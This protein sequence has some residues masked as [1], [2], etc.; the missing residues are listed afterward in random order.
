[1][2]IDSIL[3]ALLLTLMLELVFALL[4]GLRR[5]Q[6]FMVVLMNLLTNPAANLIYGLALLYTA[7]PQILLIVLLEAAVVTTETICCKGFVSKPL[8]FTLLCNAFS[9]IIGILLQSIL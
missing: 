2:I 7:V 9:Y 8:L 3:I 4:W 5:K 6:L 1:L